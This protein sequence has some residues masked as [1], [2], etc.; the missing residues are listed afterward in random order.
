MDNLLLN[1][2]E[3][4]KGKGDSNSITLAANFD[5]SNTWDVTQD[6]PE[7]TFDTR[8]L[9]YN[10]AHSRLSNNRYADKAN[11]IPKKKRPENSS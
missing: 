2:V 3:A 6:N 8:S 7:P 5:L 11:K 10:A 1:S 9:A 4:V